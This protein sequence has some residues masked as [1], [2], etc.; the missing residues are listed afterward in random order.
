MSHEAT[1]RSVYAGLNAKDTS[2]M[3]DALAEDAVF[4]ILPNPILP[5]QTLTGRDAIL[6]FIQDQMPGIDMQQEIDEISV[7]GEF[8]TVYIQ[9][10][11]T[12][13]DGA[14]QTVRW[15]DV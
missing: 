6:A 1:L 14:T 13:A 9:S 11:H 2:G 10:Q 3:K 15:A 7:N 12:D 4:H 5:P 8:A